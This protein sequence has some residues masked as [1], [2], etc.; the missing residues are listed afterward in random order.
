MT[1][2]VTRK[3]EGVALVTVLMIVAAMA[4]VA[5]TLS[6]AVLASTNRA[7]SLDASAQ[8][9]WLVFAAEEYARLSV[10][11]A[12]LAT[13][14]KLVAGMPGLGQPLVF[15]AEGGLITVVVQDGSNCFNLNALRSAST[16]SR[17]D[18][19]PAGT[20]TPSAAED[21][22]SLLTLAGLQDI[23]GEALTASII[24]WMDP[25]QA[26]GLSGAEDSYYS[27]PNLNYRTSGQPMSEMAEMLPVRYMSHDIYD[28]LQPL[29]CTL[30]K[31]EQ[32]PLNIN[33]IPESRAAL[34]SLAFSSAL[35]VEA[36]RDLIFQR[37]AGGWTSLDE[38]MALPAIAE[39][40]PELRRDG[41]LSVTA[42]Y[43]DVRSAIEYRG[44]R[45]V[46]ELDF[47]LDGAGLA[48]TI[49]RERKG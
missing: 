49:H 40:A 14:G 38:F 46:F 10:S 2:V 48:T 18:E 3:D 1:A 21:F 47:E 8:I 32:Q 42:S 41:M 16:A 27:T 13:E 19:Q 35:T 43:V 17:G 7:K 4:T 36:A 29:V 12:I 33:T 26:P 31:E 24:D 44:T 45:R 22:R 25:D 37:P 30:P 28:A 9:D 34:L 6:S 5:V 11:D 20:N 23:D 15:E 39:I